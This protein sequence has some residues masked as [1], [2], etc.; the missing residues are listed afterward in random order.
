MRSSA[1]RDTA[2]LVLQLVYEQQRGVAVM[3]PVQAEFTSNEAKTILGISRPQVYE[4]IEQGRLAHRLVGTHRRILATA[5]TAF[6]AEQH[7]TQRHAM[8]EPARL[9]NALGLAE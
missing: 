5:V 2:G 4:L 9:S 1:P 6:R 8:A 3:I 7:S